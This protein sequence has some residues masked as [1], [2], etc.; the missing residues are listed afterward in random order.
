MSRIL[1]FEVPSNAYEIQSL[2]SDTLLE[3]SYNQRGI[4]E[5][6]K[7]SAHRLSRVFF[8]TLIPRNRFDGRRLIDQTFTT[9]AP[10]AWFLYSHWQNSEGKTPYALS[11]NLR[12]YVGAAIRQERPE[13]S[14]NSLEV[15]EELV[16]IISQLSQDLGNFRNLPERQESLKDAV[17]SLATEM[18]RYETPFKRY[19][20]A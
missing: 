20:T 15:A 10:L 18:Q 11:K 6:E 13:S 3:I 9:Q 14:M 8:R 5:R 4:G 19:T 2:A 17:R 1:E 16:P 12:D 7:G